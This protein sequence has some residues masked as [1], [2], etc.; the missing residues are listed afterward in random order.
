MDIPRIQTPTGEVGTKPA[1]FAEVA[2]RT[3]KNAWTRSR[4]SPLGPRWR[5][6]APRC[7]QHRKRT[8]AGRVLITLNTES[9]CVG[10]LGT[11]MGGSVEPSFVYCSTAA[12]LAL[13]VVCPSHSAPVLGLKRSPT[14]L[15][16]VD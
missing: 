4:P 6:A 5:A 10:V 7:R 9:R 1:S 14:P 2:S 13:T 12:R 15:L 16:W 3:P 8:A 11:I